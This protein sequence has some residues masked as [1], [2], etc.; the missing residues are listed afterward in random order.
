MK[1]L[2]GL[3]NVGKVK[4]PILKYWSWLTTALVHNTKWTWRF[5]G[6]RFESRAKDVLF[7]D[8]RDIL[9]SLQLTYKR[10]RLFPVSLFWGR[11]HSKLKQLKFIQL[12]GSRGRFQWPRGLRR[13]LWSLGGWERGF[14][15]RLWHGCLS[16]SFCVVLICLGRGLYDGLI[17][18]PEET[19]EYLHIKSEI[20]SNLTC[21][22]FRAGNVYTWQV[23]WS[24]QPAHLNCLSTCLMYM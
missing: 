17:T 9:Q 22:W 14:E 7:W 24:R 1:C 15:S 10:E 12:D 4:S 2:N 20:V 21:F 16:S 11:S 8:F 18:R 6:S 19:P 23:T 3:Q 13:R 5:G